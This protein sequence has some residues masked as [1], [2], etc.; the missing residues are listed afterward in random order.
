MKRNEVNMCDQNGLFLTKS[1][2][3]SMR[4]VV[5]GLGLIHHGLDHVKDVLCHVVSLESYEPF[6][7]V[8]KREGEP[9]LS[10]YYII[11]GTV[12]A[13]YSPSNGEAI[14]VRKD[15]W[16]ALFSMKTIDFKAGRLS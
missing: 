6:Q 7:C 11:H 1:D 15:I 16:L 14:Q 4:P 12:E 5:E 3:N 8:L 9:V 2:V 13:T 10:C